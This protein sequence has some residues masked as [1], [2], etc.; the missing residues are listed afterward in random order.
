MSLDDLVNVSVSAETQS[1]TRAGFGTPL[2]PTFHTKFAERVRFYTSL[3]GMTADGFATTDAAYKGAQAVFAQNPRPSR[4]AVGRLS[5]ASVMTVDLTPVVQNDHDYVVTV[6][7]TEHETT[8]DASATAAEIVDALVTAINAGAAAAKVTA[9]NVG[10]VLHIVADTAGDMFSCEIDYRDFARVDNTPDSGDIEQQLIDISIENDEWYGLV[11]MCGSKTVIKAA[12]AY[13]ETVKKIMIAVSGDSAILDS[14]ATTD[15]ASEMKALAYARSAVI[16]SR[17]PYE[18]S[19]AAWQGEELPNDPGSST[20][21][22]KT[23][24]GISPDTFTA[25]EIATLK[26]KNCNYYMTV[27][28]INITQDGKTASGE[29]IDVTIFV[30]W[31]IARMQERIFGIMVNIKKIPFTDKGIQL[32]EGAIDAQLKE[33]VEV[34][35]LADDDTLRVIVPLAADVD[36]ADKAARSLPDVAFQGTLAGAIHDLDITGTVSV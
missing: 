7:G 25:T 33:G 22:F 13:I 5:I 4:V 26:A 12:A 31:L 36:S 29:W 23:L 16:F 6:N 15:V 18:M 3:L 34:G 30:D 10:N 11:L 35:G 32:L 19:H 1:P 28:G 9:S 17:N 20:W 8:S 14:V 24:A 2:I 21:K 27:A